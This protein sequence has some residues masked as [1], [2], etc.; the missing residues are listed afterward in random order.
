MIDTKEMEKL[1]EGWKRIKLGKVLDYE[2]PI[3][4]IVK[5]ENYDQKSGIPVL[6]AG[7]TFILGYTDETEGVFKDV[8]VII[9][10]D[11]TTESKFINFSFKVKSSALKILKLGYDRN[12]IHFLYNAMQILNFNPGS[13]HKRY[14]I[15]EYSNTVIPLPSLPEQEKIA[16]ILETVD[17]TIEKTDAIIEKYK[18]IKQGLM[19]ELLTKG[20]DS[21]WKIRSEKTHKFKD[22]PLGKITEEWEVK[23]LGEINHII[24]G[25]SPNSS[26]VNKIGNGIA[27]LQGNAEFTDKYPNPTN[28]IEKPLKIANKGNI[29]ISVRA[30]IGALNITDRQYCIGR[31][32]ASIEPYNNLTDK[33]YLWNFIHFHIN[34]LIKLGQGSTF[35]AIGSKELFNLQISLP[36]LPEQ[37]RIA[38]VISQVD[39]VIEKETAYRDKLS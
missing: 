39:A 22:S 35:E 11:F 27:F 30:P 21:N 36:P 2:Q 33:F 7:K 23:K 32:L 6:T 20:I 16:E 38:S 26:L 4:Y 29:L 19:Q 3:N 31:G 34:E 12:N 10:D 17:N 14:W 28:W 1:P 18:R 8:P 37:E 9:F 24:M 25:Q 5:S 15:S 13:E